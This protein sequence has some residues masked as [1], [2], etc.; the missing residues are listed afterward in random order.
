MRF[1]RLRVLRCRCWPSSE[2]LLTLSTGEVNA[3]LGSKVDDT[4]FQS[5]QSLKRDKEGSLSSVQT[6]DLYQTKV[7]SAAALALKRD[8][9][10]SLST[11]VI[12]AAL[13]LKRNVADSLTTGEVNAL[14]GS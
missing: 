12:D 2:I 14:L 13:L 3:L 8:T 1:S 6:A 7:D 4:T 11:A 9:A 10:T 5:G